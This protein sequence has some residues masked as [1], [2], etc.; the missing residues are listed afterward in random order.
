[1]RYIQIPA[2]IE[3]VGRDAEGNDTEPVELSFDRWLI[4]NPLLDPEWGKDT[5]SLFMAHDIKHKVKRLDGDV[6]E[7]SDAE[8]SKL[9]AVVEK[10]T[11]GLN[12]FLALQI[13]DFMRAVI[14]ATDKEPRAQPFEAVE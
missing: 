3:I 8:W 13:V 10:P 11:N 14:D 1:M 7:L 4:N 9:K 2:P 12:T 5:R 6:L